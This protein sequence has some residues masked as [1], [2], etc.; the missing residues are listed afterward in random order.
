M[1]IRR[2]A[3]IALAVTLCLC[4][5][6]ACTKKASTLKVGATSAPHAEILEQVKPVL[7]QQGIT[8]EITVFTDYPLINTAVAEGTL[9]ANYFQHQP[10]LDSYNQNNG[11]NIVSAGAIHYEPMAAFGGKTSSLEELKEGSVVAVPNDETNEAR[12]LLLLEAQGLIKLPENAGLSVTVTDIT[13]N[14]KNL[15]FKELNAEQLPRSLEDVDLAV[16]NGNYALEGGL[17]LSDALAFEAADSLAAETYANIIAV[18]SGDE[19]KAEIKALVAALQ[20]ETIRKFIIDKYQ[21]AVVP[22]F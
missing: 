13:E 3:F 12:A 21:G 7:A 20:S 16:I 5:L 4:L 1:K 15:T 22:K 9:D 11:T 6:P 10:Y 8:L 14:P 2:I 17:K 18:R 19:N